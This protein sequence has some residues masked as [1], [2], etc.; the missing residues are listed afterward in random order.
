MTSN[1]NPHIHPM[2]NHV[3]DEMLYYII[4]NFRKTAMWKK[5]WM[6]ERFCHSEGLLL[7]KYPDGSPSSTWFALL[8]WGASNIIEGIVGGYWEQNEK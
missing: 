3:I 4:L 8:P 6:S 2:S 7:E 5:G 1:C